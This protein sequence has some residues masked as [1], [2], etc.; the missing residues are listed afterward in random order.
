[1]Q[2]TRVVA[3]ASSHGDRRSRA[4][5]ARAARWRA[6]PPSS[7]SRPGLSRIAGPGARDRRGA[8]TSASRR[9]CRRSRSPSRS[10]TWCARCSPTPRSRARSCRCS[11]SCSRRGER[12]EAFR[13]AS[14]LFFLITLVARRAHARS[15]SCSPADH[16]AVRAGLRRQPGAHRPDGQLAR[17]M[18]PIV[19]LLALSGLV[20]GML[21][22][23]EHFAVPA[24]APVA[25]NLVIIAALVGLVPVLPEGDADL[26]LRDR[27]PGRHDR[28]VP[29][30]AAVAARAR[31]P[32]HAHARLAQRARAPRAEADAAGDDRARADQLQP[33]DQLVLRHARLDQAPAAIDK[34]FRIYLLPQGLFSSRSRRSCSRRCRASPRAAHTTTCAARWPTACARSACC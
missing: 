12:K 6:A 13:V 32:A 15:S 7:R 3:G 26:R 17:I 27:R 29:A 21:N 1:M 19:L 2:P 25:W 5:P 28:P 24:L 9:R 11:P 22:S 8:A 16:A 14:S 30:A 33:A 4:P 34:A 20:V 10:R 23:F 18:F 31:R